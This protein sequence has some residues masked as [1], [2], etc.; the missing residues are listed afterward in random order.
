MSQSGQGGAKPIAILITV[1]RNESP[2]PAQNRTDAGLSERRVTMELSQVKEIM[3]E[4]ELDKHHNP[5][6]I[7]DGG[8]ALELGNRKDMV[9]FV[10]L[11]FQKGM[12]YQGILYRANIFILN[13]DGTFT[14]LYN[15][16]NGMRASKGLD[17]VFI[18]G[19]VRKIYNEDCVVV[20]ETQT[21][22][23]AVVSGSKGKV[24]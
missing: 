5:V 24:E 1:F 12:S 4:L 19:F 11:I 16:P 8:E 14:L 17:K 9:D 18:E 10:M 3:K 23:Y 13:N 2:C 15:D 7:K 22:R 6:V 20:Y 21:D